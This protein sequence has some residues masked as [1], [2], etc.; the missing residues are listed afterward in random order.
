MRLDASGWK[1][2][3]MIGTLRVLSYA[4]GYAAATASRVQAPELRPAYQSCAT[5]RDSTM[6][7][8][9]TNYSTDDAVMV[10]QERAYTS[11]IWYSP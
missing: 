8:W 3:Q 2:S 1:R 6:L 4:I 11:P 10:Q 5:S 9:P 7:Y